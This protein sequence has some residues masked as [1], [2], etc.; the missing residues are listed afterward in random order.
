MASN[1]IFECLIPGYH[2][3]EQLHEG[4][5]TTLCR[6]YRHNDRVPVL[7]QILHPEYCLPQYVEQ[8]KER[9]ESSQYLAV[10]GLVRTI[11]FVMHGQTPAIILEDMAGQLWQTALTERQ[12]SIEEI[13][14]VALELANI[15]TAL[16]AKQY[17]HQ[18]IQPQRILIHPETHQV[19]VLPTPAVALM[20]DQNLNQHS[21][22][23]SILTALAYASPEQTGR[24]NTAIDIRSDFYNLGVTLYQ[25]CVG[26]LPFPSRD[27]N[28]LIHS[29]IARPAPTPQAKNRTIPDNLS[30]IILKLL[31]KNPDERY[32][33]AYGL[34]CDLSTSLE[35]CRNQQE[36]DNF[37]PGQTDLASELSIPQRLYDRQNEL[38]ILR[39]TYE[40]A[41][42]GNIQTVLITGESGVGKSLLVKEFHSQ[43]AHH[44]GYFIRGNC[45]AVRRE[46][47][48]LALSNAF[49]QLFCQLLTEDE[50]TIQAWRKRLLQGLG[51]R[52]AILCEIMPEL[53]QIIGPQPTDLKV[54]SAE[55]ENRLN[56]AFQAFLQIFAQTP[57]PLVL[58]IDDLQWI[59]TASIKLLEHVL[60]GGQPAALMLIT[61]CRFG[62]S[63]ASQEIDLRLMRNLIDGPGRRELSLSPFSS[64]QMQRL[65]ADVLHTSATTIVELAE[66]IF[67]RTQGNPFFAHQLLEFL[68]HEELLIFNFDQ[69]QWNWDLEQ[70]R[71]FGV[72]ENVVE[73][74]EQKILKLSSQTREILQLAA[75]IGIDFDTE[76]IAALSPIPNAD[77]PQALA[78]A[79][80]EGL[81][82]PLTSPDSS[83]YS[84]LSDLGTAAHFQFL[85][86]RVR[87]AF[88][89][90][91]EPDTRQKLHW[92]IGQRLLQKMLQQR[93]DDQ[94]FEVVNQLN[95]GRAF[96]ID[97]SA[98]QELAHLNLRASRR[99][100]QAA[101]YRSAL[102]YV[103]AGS[104]LLPDESWSKDYEL[105]RDLW[106]EQAECQ[107]LGGNFPAA[108][109][110][111]E[112]ICTHVKT[113]TELVD[114][115]TVQI[116]CY[117]NQNRHQ[118][119]SALGRLGLAKL[120][121]EVP[122]SLTE[123]TVLDQLNQLRLRLMQYSPAYFLAL[124]TCE[125]REVQQILQLLQYFA[126]ATISQDQ[127]LYRWA[128]AQMVQRSI[129]GG[130]TDRSAYAY[131]AYGTILSSGFGDY[132]RGHQLGQVALELSQTF[133]AMQGLAH[134]SYGGL[135]AHWRIQFTEC[136][137]HLDSAFQHCQR[138]GELLYALYS[139]ALKTDL[140]IMSGHNLEATEATI[141][142]FS[143]FAAQRQHPIMQLDALL[144]LQFVRSLRG[145]TQDASSFSSA[146]H[147]EADLYQQLH[148]A[149][150]PK[151]TRSRYYI[152]K[153]Q[154]LYTFGYHQSALEMATASAEIIDAHFGPAIVVEHYLYHG[155]VVAAL[156]D[157]ADAATQNSYR[158]IL[159]HCLQ[160]MQRWSY[161]CPSNFTARWHL[162]AG[163]QE[164]IMGEDPTC[165]Y[166]EAIGLA[167]A[168]GMLQICAIANELAGEY[169]WK[170]QHQRIARAYLNDACLAYQQWGA[171]AKATALQQ[172]Y[173]SLLTWRG[174]FASSTY[175]PLATEAATSQRLQTLDWMTIIKASQ[176]LSS[177]IVYS[178]LL[179]KLLTILMENA[180]AERGI[181]LTRRHQTFEI[182]AEGN[183]E[184]AEIVFQLKQSAPTA[185]DL[186]IN[187]LTYVERTRETILLDEAIHDL[188]FASDP[189]IQAHKL[190][191]VLCFPIV[192]QGKQ[193]GL[194][195]LENRLIVGAF[196]P[197]QLEVVRLLTSQVSIS[198]EN[199]QLYADAQ[200]H[201]HAAETQNLE[202]IKSQQ[203]LQAKTEQVEATLED[204]KQTQ[205]QL[206]Q[207]EK[208]SGLGQLVA[209]V[210]HEVKNPLNFIQG[211][212]EYANQYISQIFSLLERYQ[213]LYPEPPAELQTLLEEIDLEFVARDLPK[214]LTSMTLGTDRIQNIVSSLRT[215][216][217][218]DGDE[219]ELTNLQDGVEGTLLILRSRFNAN[220]NRPGIEV[221]KEFSE[222][223]EI[224]CYAG[225]LNQ[226]VMN[227]IANSIDAIDEQATGFSFEANAEN[228]K[229]ITIVTEQVD[230]DCIA[231]RVRDNGPG[232]SPATQQKIF[233]TFFTTKPAGQGTGLGLSISHQIITEKHGGRLLCKSQLGEG[234]E[235]TIMLPIDP[236]NALSSP[237]GDYLTFIDS[238]LLS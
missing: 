167:Q 73:L 172:K 118:E 13:L 89:G 97:P 230:Q 2:I 236:T 121:V 116:V 25:A 218:T 181:L 4:M 39:Q 123:A 162:L 81:V 166:D 225:Q 152:Y 91:I 95:F 28:E 168:H 85:H 222:L 158:S 134:F 119:A 79:V 58:F 92:Q 69:G 34:K 29:H 231:I 80:Q 110:A 196:T 193:T 204:L 226:V 111:F 20:G 195:Y 57:H 21:S 129:D 229:C 23:K 131:V 72:T 103:L 190:K 197:A 99:A 24:M 147:Q 127:S 75:C 56:L 170:Q 65:V 157:Y 128:I 199:A 130:N 188:R 149:K 153:A 177:E 145:L 6:G 100:K 44:R 53:V 3:T 93:Q 173:R 1:S 64:E 202:L 209:G 67:H 41:S 139:S 163:E 171:I 223:P 40:Q 27:M 36:L 159:A 125:D 140:L 12:W 50:A 133:Q 107:Y 179:E 143:R 37:C 183:V 175:L 155:L 233:E 106:L 59:D 178:S 217:R 22:P 115:Y 15:L 84:T 63:S 237:D 194:L 136:I 156:H 160:Q 146:E 70:I 219:K 137:Q 182:E 48:Y 98:K 201:L 9:A 235:F 17:I 10:D 87:Q 144:K 220:S 96:V 86:D 55:A 33:S 101:A 203:Q 151:P 180:G 213:A 210:A 150:T 35:A 117:I 165:H 164:R 206:V 5:M 94:L 76:M 122:T 238:S 154:S 8:F 26:S 185:E 42:H 198:V 88:Y 60:A 11:D 109:T 192:Y 46:V 189:Y 148:A 66:L 138:R 108:E 224:S 141:N 105:T 221:V 54:E 174:N 184:Q 215:F 126:A 124:P 51:D 62:N 205:A 234:S 214:L 68:Y 211:N 16:H 18:Q 112:Q 232:M 186:P 161:H 61:A 47:P 31:A 14:E 113:V 114:V 52:A 212:L 120:N 45:D 30:R 187:L 208:M 176:A 7:L 78:M 90:L 169:Y 74:M 71:H 19:Q 49:Q 135:L 38:G 102:Q 77:I 207:T 132:D 104:S 228:P 216:S 82:I 32:Q 142:A 191:S 43:I 83:S 200:E 227:L